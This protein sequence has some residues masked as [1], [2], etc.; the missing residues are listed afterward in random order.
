M[1]KHIESSEMNP[2]EKQ[3]YKNGSTFSLLFDIIPRSHNRER[4]WLL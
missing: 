3:T 4:L 2:P 1:F